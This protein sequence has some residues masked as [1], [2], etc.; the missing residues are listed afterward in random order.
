[1]TGIMEQPSPESVRL[2]I[3][4]PVFD[5]MLAHCRANY[6]NEACGILAGKNMAVSE[7]FL[8][9]NTEKSPVELKLDRDPS[10]PSGRLLIF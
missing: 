1:M 2:V 6:P 7:I 4:A 10:K 9:T 3:P 5:S 8:M